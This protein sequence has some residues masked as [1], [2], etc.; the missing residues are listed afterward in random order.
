M[1]DRTALTF[2]FDGLFNRNDVH[3]D[4]CSAK[5]YH[6]GNALERHLGHE[7]E[8]GRKFRML[9]GQLIVHHHELGGTRNEDRHIVNHVLVRGFTVC[10][11]DTDPG[12]MIEHLLGVLDAHVV[13][14]RD[15]FEIIRHSCLLE[16][17]QELHF[18][19]CQNRIEHPVLRIIHIQGSGV[20]LEIPVGDHRTEL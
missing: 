1:F 7:V 16:R 5:R 20:L 18:L 9:G 3:A 13:H 17:K 2:V 8:E 10:L 14:F 6:R 11:N 19:L 15:I 12:Q 4:A